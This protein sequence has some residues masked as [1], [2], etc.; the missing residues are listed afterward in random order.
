MSKI[1][2]MK[3]VIED[4]YVFRSEF[5]VTQEVND[6]I[7]KLF[8]ILKMIF[9]PQFKIIYWVKEKRIKFILVA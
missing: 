6:G 9:K 5:K 8:L 7:Q 2:H 4:Q 1:T 3:K